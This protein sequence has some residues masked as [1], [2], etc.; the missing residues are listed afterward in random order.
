MEGSLDDQPGR[1]IPGTRV[2]GDESELTRSTDI[3]IQTGE[4]IQRLELTFRSGNLIG[5]V[6]VVDF[7]N[8]AP[9]VMTVEQLGELLLGRM[10]QARNQPGPQLGDRALRITPLVP[11]IESG[12]LRDFYVRIDGVDQP[13]YAQIVASIRDERPAPIAATPVAGAPVRSRDTYMFWTPVGEGDPL[14]LP[15]YVSWLNRFDSPQQAAAA[16]GAVTANLGSGY[17]NVQELAIIGE[18]VGDESRTFAYH[19]NGDPDAPVRG[20]VVMAQIGSYL[21]RVQV[22]GPNGVHQAGVETLAKQQVACLEMPEP[23]EPVVMLEVLA[24]L[25]ALTAEQ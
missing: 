10:E 23:C 8:I 4:P 13:M 18:R 9:E 15:L 3:D 20:I 21:V 5:E 22:D 1:D 16:L 24:D 19:Y 6:S 25:V 14:Q 11:W 12:R 17:E 2:F 7:E